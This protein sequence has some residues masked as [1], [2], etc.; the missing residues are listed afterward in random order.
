MP[1]HRVEEPESPSQP[2]AG[3]L[4]RTVWVLFGNLAIGVIGLKIVIDQA[5]LFSWLD[6]LFWLMVVL[7]IGARYVDIRWFQG[8]TTRSEPATM[9]HWRMHTLYLLAISGAGWGIAHAV[10]YFF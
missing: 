8:M 7:V 1:A 9:R 5:Q 4:F 10:S 6:L 2:P 3:C